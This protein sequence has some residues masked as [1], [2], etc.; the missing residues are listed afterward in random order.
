MDGDQ[1]VELTR[2]APTR[3]RHTHRD[4]RMQIYRYVG[5]VG[6]VLTLNKPEQVVQYAPYVSP[7][8]V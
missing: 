4:L 6:R 5:G 7:S 8:V 1:L 3:E 2:D